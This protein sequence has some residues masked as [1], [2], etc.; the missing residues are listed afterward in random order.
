MPQNSIAQKVIAYLQQDEPDYAEAAKL[1]D[2][3]MP[4]LKNI[5]MGSD[6]ALASKATCLASMISSDQK[7]E[8]LKEAAQHPSVIVRLAA[9]AAAKQLPDHEAE[10]LV[11]HLINDADIGVSKYTLQT[12]KSKKLSQKFKT[13]LTEMSEKNPNET[14]KNLATDALKSGG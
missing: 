12:I 1:G 2:E 13:R 8:A 4:T 10:E 3:A 11:R 14:I 6:E 5:I 9:A 7:A